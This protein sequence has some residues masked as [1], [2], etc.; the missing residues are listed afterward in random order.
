M[1][2]NTNY[3]SNDETEFFSVKFPNTEIKYTNYIHLGRQIPSKSH[4]KLS[5]ITFEQ[6][7]YQWILIFIITG[8]LTMVESIQPFHPHMGQTIHQLLSARLVSP[9]FGIIDIAVCTSTP[10][11]CT[12]MCCQGNHG[13]GM[14]FDYFSVTFPEI[15]NFKCLQQNIIDFPMALQCMQQVSIFIC[16]KTFS[17]AFNFVALNS[18]LIIITNINMNRSTSSHFSDIICLYQGAR[19]TFTHYSQKISIIQSYYHKGIKTLYLDNHHF[20]SMG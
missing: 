2:I 3:S 16:E 1:S 11:V 15:L 6:K 20:I 7:E 13:L 9:V 19:N 17:E 4:I 8:T 18:L 10:S 12:D 5:D 14:L